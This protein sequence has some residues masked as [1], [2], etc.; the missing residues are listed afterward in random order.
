MVK[1]V[2]DDYGEELVNMFNKKKKELTSK[3]RR[4]IYDDILL[5]NL[6]LKEQLQ[7]AFGEEDAHLSFGLSPHCDPG[8]LFGFYLN[9]FLTSGEKYRGRSDSIYLNMSLSFFFIG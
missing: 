5:S 4:E 3:S 8:G 2:M 1:E 6:R 7:E 9:P